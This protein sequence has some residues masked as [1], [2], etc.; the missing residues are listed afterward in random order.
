MALYPFGKH[1]EPVACCHV[2]NLLNKGAHRGP[3]PCAGK[4]GSRASTCPSEPTW[5]GR[6]GNALTGENLWRVL[7]AGIGHSH[8]NSNGTAS[9]FLSG[10]PLLSVTA[11][12][13][14]MM[15][16]GRLDDP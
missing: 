14:C 8:I 7:S 5:P 12:G 15:I 16:L 2:R 9:L 3:Y 1:M 11:T 10:K 4:E 6:C 13:E